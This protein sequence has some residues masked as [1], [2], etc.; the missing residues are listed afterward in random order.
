[1]NEPEKEK[2]FKSF[3]QNQNKN[4]FEDDWIKI[5]REVEPSR[6]YRGKYEK[7][8]GTKAPTLPLGIQNTRPGRKYFPQGRRVLS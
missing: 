3:F 2:V 8:R 7:K 1:M 5:M 4:M 6:E